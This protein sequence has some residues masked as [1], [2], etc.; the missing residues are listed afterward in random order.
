MTIIQFSS[1]KMQS[2]SDKL[3]G[4]GREC[5][6]RPRVGALVLMMNQAESNKHTD[7]WIYRQLEIHC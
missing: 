1:K 5:N 7:Y 4:T 2:Q 3:P 6:G